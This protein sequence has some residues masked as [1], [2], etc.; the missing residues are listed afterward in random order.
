MGHFPA[1]ATYQPGRLQVANNRLRIG[2][3]AP[4]LLR[5]NWWGTFISIATLH[6]VLQL[7]DPIYATLFALM[8]GCAS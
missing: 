8:V 2:D 3:K 4:E 5:R 1:K 6:R 7:N